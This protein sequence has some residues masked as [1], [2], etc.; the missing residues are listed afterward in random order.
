MSRYSIRFRA[1]E[2]WF[3]AANHFGLKL[4]TAFYL[5]TYPDGGRLAELF[6]LGF[7]VQ[8]SRAA[9]TEREK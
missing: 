1:P 9:A 4:N 6:V 5:T 2:F 7:G 3:Y 8:L